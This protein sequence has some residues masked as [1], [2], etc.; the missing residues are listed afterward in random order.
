M[1][2]VHDPNPLCVSC[3]LTITIPDQSLPENRVAWAKLE[4]LVEGAKLASQRL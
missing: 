3:R 1:A 2:A 4:S